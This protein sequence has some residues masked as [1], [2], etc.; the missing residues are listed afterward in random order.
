[1]ILDTIA[2]APKYLAM[3]GGMAAACEFLGRSDLGELAPGRYEID[4]PR[5]LR[6]SSGPRAEAR[7]APGWK[8][9]AGTSTFKS[10][11]AAAK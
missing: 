11:S 8:S 9:I 6:L 2:G 10:R 1:M 5:V 4:G 3:H 7:R